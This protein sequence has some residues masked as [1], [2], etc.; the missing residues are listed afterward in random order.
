[1]IRARLAGREESGRGSQGQAP[2]GK[3]G[4][5][6]ELCGTHRLKV[7]NRPGL[8]GEGPGPSPSLQEGSQELLGRPP[9]PPLLASPVAWLA[10]PGRAQLPGV[11]RDQRAESRP[12][13]SPT[14][15]GIR[16]PRGRNPQPHSGCPGR[17]KARVG[18]GWSA[19]TGST[20]RGND[21]SANSQVGGHPLPGPG[22]SLYPFCPPLRASVG[23]K[24]GS[25]PGGLG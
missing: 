6:A 13:P 23:P 16:G 19:K 24:R 11:G 1:M 10:R 14:E 3:V 17:H 5:G 21:A 22:G 8:T 20:E 7:G 12:P 9:G 15:T 25:W 2:L 18:Q 4:G